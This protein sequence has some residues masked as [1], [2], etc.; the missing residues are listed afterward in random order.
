M[1]N[2]TFLSYSK[3]RTYETST[4]TYIRKQLVL[5]TVLLNW[6]RLTWK[7]TDGGKLSD[8]FV[9]GRGNILIRMETHCAQCLIISS[10][11]LFLSFC[12]DCVCSNSYLIF[13]AA[14]FFKASKLIL[15]MC[16]IFWNHFLSSKS[17]LRPKLLLV[18]AYCSGGTA[19][20]FSNQTNWWVQSLYSPLSA[21]FAASSWNAQENRLSTSVEYSVLSTMFHVLN[22]SKL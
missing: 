11:A 21:Q 16:C 1:V 4:T 13:A 19:N 6:R 10:S 14:A 5:V 9:A 3:Q 22:Y 2:I 18:S 15:I 7:R 17:H 8:V 12:H 20:G